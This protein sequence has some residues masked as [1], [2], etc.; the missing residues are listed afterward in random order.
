VWRGRG[1]RGRRRGMGGRAAGG[2]EGGS[3]NDGWMWWCVVLFLSVGRS[4][5]Q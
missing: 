4:G 3:G 1:E 2:G 5:I